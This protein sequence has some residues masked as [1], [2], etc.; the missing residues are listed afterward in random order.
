MCV[1]AL[2]VGPEDES[3]TTFGGHLGLDT[4]LMKV[5]QQQVDDQEEFNLLISYLKIDPTASI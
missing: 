2:A 3:M 4:E 1:R 5:L